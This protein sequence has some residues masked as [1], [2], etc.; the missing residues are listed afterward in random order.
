MYT[1]LPKTAT[2][3]HPVPPRMIS[4]GKELDRSKEFQQNRYLLRLTSSFL[5]VEIRHG[6]FLTFSGHYQ[7]ARQLEGTVHGLGIGGGHR[8]MYVINCQ[9]NLSFE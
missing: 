1:F 5:E 4:S 2:F 3:Y 8:A 6:H 7:Q 9:N